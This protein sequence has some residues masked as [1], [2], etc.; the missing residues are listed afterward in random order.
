LLCRLAHDFEGGN[1]ASYFRLYMVLN[2]VLKTIKLIRE[3]LELI[4]YLSKFQIFHLK[5]DFYYAI[6]ICYLKFTNVIQFYSIKN[7]NNII[8]H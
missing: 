7:V 4:C 3:L 6:K 1:C 5:I 8:L 2:F